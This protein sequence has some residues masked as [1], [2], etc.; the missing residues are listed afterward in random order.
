MFKRV[1]LPDRLVVDEAPHILAADQR[2]VLAEFGPVEFEQAVAVLA[3]F[4][5]HLGED[6][7]AGR[8]LGPQAFGDIGVDAV[9]LFLVGDR[10]GEDFPLGQ[11]GEIAHA[12]QCGQARQGVKWNR[13]SCKCFAGT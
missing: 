12:G 10:Q 6:M 7:G 3:F 9:V 1:D 11:V 4:L 5:G 8:V 2:D 13:K